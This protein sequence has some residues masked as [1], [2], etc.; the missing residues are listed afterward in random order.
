MGSRAQ[1]QLPKTTRNPPKPTELS[2]RQSLWRVVGANRPRYDT[3]ET[4][5]EG[6]LEVVFAVDVFNQG[7]MSP[8]IDTR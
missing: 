7:W 8:E 6:R 1:P 3:A 4:L 2:E 5:R